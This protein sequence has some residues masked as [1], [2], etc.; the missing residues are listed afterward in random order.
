VRAGAA[1]GA[2]DPGSHRSFDHDGVRSRIREY[3]REIHVQGVEILTECGGD[4]KAQA[5]QSAAQIVA[6]Q[7]LLGVS[8]DGDV[9][10][11]DQHFD[12]ELLRH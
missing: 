8:G 2:H 10:V 11:V 4:A 9:V 7:V 5:R 6:G 3:P 1:L 12:V